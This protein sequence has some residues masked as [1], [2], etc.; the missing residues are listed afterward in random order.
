MKRLSAVVGIF[1]VATIGFG[2]AQALD[3]SCSINGGSA[4][5]PHVHDVKGDQMEPTT[6]VPMPDGTDVLSAWFARDHDGVVTAN[7]NVGSLNGAELNYAYYFSWTFRGE[8]PASNELRWVA[9]Q[10]RPDAPSGSPV[11][12]GPRYSYGYLDTTSPGVQRLVL[13][14]ESIGSVKAGTPGFVSVVVPLE[15]M[16]AP[17][18][19]D[20]LSLILVQTRVLFGNPGFP[21]GYAPPTLPSG[22]PTPPGGVALTVDTSANADLCDEILV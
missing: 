21:P 22:T 7:I 16:G 10:P 2:P 5:T 17:R 4:D 11:G 20:A 1:L 8:G 3:G 18:P 9:V 6:A 14:G 13:E 19:G 15:K 12:Y